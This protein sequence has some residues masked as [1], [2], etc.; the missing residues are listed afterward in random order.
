MKISKQQ[1]YKMTKRHDCK[2]I[3]TFRTEHDSGCVKNETLCH[4]FWPKI[5]FTEMAEKQEVQMRLYV[6]CKKICLL[7][8]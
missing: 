3:A 2:N 5:L 6:T 1:K 7:G 8:G 4:C